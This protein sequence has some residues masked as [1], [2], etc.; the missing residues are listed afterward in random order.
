MRSLWSLLS[1]RL[2]EPSSQPVFVREVIQPSDTFMALSGPAP[3]ALCLSCAGGPWPEYST[4][5]PYKGRAEGDS[6]LPALLP[7]LCCCSPGY[8]R[9]SGLQSHTAGS[10]PTFCPPGARV[11]FHRAGLKE[12]FSLSVCVLGIAPIIVQHLA[13]DLVEPH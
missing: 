9:P 1:S 10:C 6:L 8:S 7:P 2:N 3:P 5:G 4:L 12:F 11:L 13:L